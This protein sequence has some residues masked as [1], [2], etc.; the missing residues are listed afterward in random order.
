MIIIKTKLAIGSLLHDIGKVAY[1][2]GSNTNH[3]DL[4]YYFLKG[5]T[6]DYDIL[7]CV[8]YHH[9]SNIKSASALKP[10][11]ICYITY[12]AD[13]I[14]SFVDRRKDVDSTSEGYVRDASLDST[15]NQIKNCKIKTSY[16][17]RS[18]LNSPN[19]PTENSKTYDSQ[20][21]DFIFNKFSDILKSISLTPEYIHSLIE[22]SKQVLSYVPSSTDVSQLKDISL[23]AHVKLTT[24]FALCIY[25]YL[26]A[27]NESN[28]KKVLFNGAKNFYDKPVFIYYTGKL[29]GLTDFIYK[30]DKSKSKTLKTLAMRSFYSD[31][32]TDYVADEIL[33]RLAL[34]RCNLLSSGGGTFAL[35]LPNTIDTKNIIAKIERELR[36][37]LIK[38]FGTSISYSSVREYCSANLFKNENNSFVNMLSNLS[39]KLKGFSIEY[40]IDDIISLNSRKLSQD[41]PVCA[42]CKSVY[43]IIFNNKGIAKCHICSELDNI[44]YNTISDNFITIIEDNGLCVELPF[45]KGFVID[46][47]DSLNNRNSYV[48][49]YGSGIASNCYPN[50]WFNNRVSDFSKNSKLGVLL[51]NVDGLKEFLSYS[52]NEDVAT[53]SRYTELSD[54]LAKFFKYD[55]IY[56]LKHSNFFTDNY[57]TARD[58]LV[59]NSNSSELVAIGPWDDLLGFAIDVNDEFG[60]Y[61]NHTLT[62]SGSLVYFTSNVYTSVNMANNYLKKSK[63][64]K[65]KGTIS[66]FDDSFNFDWFT[67]KKDII[68]NIFKPIE[69]NTISH[70]LLTNSS[71]RSILASLNA[72]SEIYSIPKI[73]YLIARKKPLCSEPDYEKKL[74]IYNEFKD[75]FYKWLTSGNISHLK[76]AIILYLAKYSN[77]HRM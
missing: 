72:S 15:F 49:T 41:E 46:T 12:I 74:K 10:D 11:D 43:N 39:S 40:S 47:N 29:N 60:K 59:I 68:T 23:Y 16:E 73:L 35:L 69:T 37:Y 32:L 28:Y 33:N 9:S 61:T 75:K 36:S 57:N 34:N 3:S 4:G 44:D 25:D 30:L 55:I 63:L 71:L 7:N 58:I 14:A 1:R 27:N 42:D 17:L 5:F 76:F 6:K 31:F 19:T 45:G 62:I 52:I 22:L 51:L 8:K 67:L 54:K 77:L 66:I 2:T 48:R 20:V 65:G 24:A 26:Q 13:N 53:I 64:F 56:L 21:Y 70:Q 18:S 50:N 38:N